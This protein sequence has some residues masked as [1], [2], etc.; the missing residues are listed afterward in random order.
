MQV[1]GRWRSGGRSQRVERQVIAV[2]YTNQ[3]FISVGG[4]KAASNSG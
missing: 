1:E 4:A 2:Q 3:P